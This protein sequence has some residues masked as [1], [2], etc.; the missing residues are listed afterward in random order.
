MF[1]LRLARSCLLSAFPCLLLT[2]SAGAGADLL[3][4]EGGQVQVVIVL[5][6]AQAMPGEQTAAAELATYLEKMTGAAFETVP[7]TAVRAGAAAIYLGDTRF[8]R[9]HEIDPERL[10]AEES[11]VRT[12][13]GSLV[14]TG[15]RPRGTLYG[16][17]DFLENV[18]GCRWYTPFA[19]KVPSRPTLTVGALDRRTQPY[20]HFRSHYTHLGGEGWK[21]FNVRNRIN[22]VTSSGPLD[23]AVGGGVAYGP[24]IGG[25]HGFAPYLPADKYF[26]EHPEYYSMREGKRVPSNG[27]DGNHACLS[28]PDVLKIITEGVLEDIRANPTAYCFTVAVNDGGSSTLCDCPECR[29]IAQQYGATEERCTDGGLMIWFVNQ[30]ADAVRQEFPDKYIRTLAYGPA[31]RPPVGIKARDNVIVHVCAGPRSE[32]VWLPKGTDSYELENLRE[33]CNFADHIWV[34][35]YALSC[36]HHPQGLRPITWKMDEQMKLFHRLGA[37]AGMFQENEI[38]SAEDTMFAQFYE[39]NMWIYARLCQDP[40]QDVEALISDFLEGYYGAAGRP[41]REY[42]SLVESRLPGHPYRTF[43]W[44]FMRRAQE[45]FDQAEAAVRDAPE[46]LDRVRVS[47]IPLDLSALCWRNTLL[48]DYLKQGGRLEE[49]PFRISALKAR[50]LDTLASTQHPYMLMDVSRYWLQSQGRKNR[51]PMREIV[52]RYLEEVSAGVEYTPLPEPFRAL[53]ADRVIDLTAP[54]FAG[55]HFPIVVPDEQATLGLAVPRTEKIEM[56]MYIGYWSGVPGHPNAGGVTIRP[57][58]VPGPGYHLYRGPTFTLN[59]WTYL[60]LTASWQLQEHLFTLYDPAHP[61]RKWTAYASMKF[62]GPDYPHGREGEPKGL[63]L[64]RLILVQEPD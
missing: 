52:R 38:L 59:E 44:A 8:A 33:W 25:G 46:L 20:M 54:L 63:F 61:D 23:E 14:I 53:P 1:T 27:L 9:A 17:Y 12:V 11:V 57:E 18:L 19:E 56:P 37:I 22:E 31:A 43:D 30:V 24:R 60:Y 51:E 55:D 62:S 26:A 15:G 3:L 6:R 39:M 47:R 4:A 35:D 41:L 45:L 36:Y 13:E 5:N 32:A 42:I 34:W 48:R 49:Y 29:K 64:D 21:M 58:D 2:A 16:V 28:N 50:V 40:T 10:G 7:E